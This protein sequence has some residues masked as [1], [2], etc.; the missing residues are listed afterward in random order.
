VRSAHSWGTAIDI[1]PLVNP[2]VRGRD[3][4]PPEGAPFA[5]RSTPTQGGIYAGGAVVEAFARI[6]WGWGG[7]WVA[8]QDFQHFSATGN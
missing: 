7:D 3:V 1:N 2:W 5:D 8:S 6:G 4:D